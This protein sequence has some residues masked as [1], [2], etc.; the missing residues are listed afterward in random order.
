VNSPLPPGGV[1]RRETIDF[2][3]SPTS[4]E[5]NFALFVSLQGFFLSLELFP[6]AHIGFCR[7]GAHTIYRF[8]HHLGPHALQGP[9]VPL[10]LL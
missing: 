4:L 7:L 1:R 9:L 10:G 3:V 2:F 6:F 8:Y 5:R